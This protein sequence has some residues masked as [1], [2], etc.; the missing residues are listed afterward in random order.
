L[1]VGS[2]ELT[3]GQIARALFAR[4]D[5]MHR[6]IVLKLRLPRVLDAFA[7]G[8]LLALA[9]TL[10][11]V[12]L[13]NPLADPYVLGVAGGAALGALLALAL[14]LA[15][16]GVSTG[17]LCGALLTLA[18]LVLLAR[19][20]RALHTERLLLIGVV[21]ASGLS[22]LSALILTLAPSAQLR[23]ML[24]WLMGDLSQAAGAWPMWLVAL[25]LVTLAARNARA[26]NVLSVGE[27]KARSLGLNVERAKWWIYLCAAAATAAAV[28]SVGSIGFVGLLT[29]HILRQ[30][31]CTD[32]RWLVPGSA[33]LGGGLLVMADL[34]GRTAVS[35][36]QLP[37]GVV[38]ALIGVPLMLWLLLR[39][40]R[41][42]DA[43]A[44]HRQLVD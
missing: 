41:R 20:E 14:G 10:L 5:P 16:F 26:L 24:F 29:P 2:V 19:R 23:G 1:L 30:M 17:A 25:V 3:P 32:H 34:V 37:T 13:R 4:G 9:G 33:L 35:P 15:A 38:T 31:G 22:A 11:Q 40:Q 28:A 44:A 18:F 43:D 6:A 27:L 12:L 8:A 36:T 21:L 39:A 42:P 7:A